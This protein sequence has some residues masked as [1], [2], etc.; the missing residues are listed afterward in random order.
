M[1]KT[2]RVIVTAKQI[3]RIT[4]GGTL[5]SEEMKQLDIPVWVSSYFLVYTGVMEKEIIKEK[6]TYQ[7]V[8]HWGTEKRIISWNKLAETVSWRVFMGGCWI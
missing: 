4:L 1:Q 2:D 3:R 8:L 7:S 6:V 5:M